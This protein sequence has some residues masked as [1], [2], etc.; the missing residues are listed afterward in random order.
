MNAQVNLPPDERAG[1]PWYRLELRC[2]GWGDASGPAL[3]AE[4]RLAVAIL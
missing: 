1:C 2:V 3:N 4:N